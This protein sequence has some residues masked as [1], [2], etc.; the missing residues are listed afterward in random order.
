MQVS[1][2]HGGKWILRHNGHCFL[3]PANLGRKIK[4]GQ[5]PVELN[6]ALESVQGRPKKTVK[7]KQQLLSKDT[8]RLLAEKTVSLVSNYSLILQ[9]ALSTMILVLP[10]TSTARAI[11]PMPFLLFLFSAFWHELGHATALV[12]HGRRPGAIGV[13][14]L[15]IFPV[16][17]C[18][19]TATALLDRNQ[20]IR[21]DIS[22][23]IF[24]LSFAS[25]LHLLAIISGIS[26]F[27][28][29]SKL[30]LMA[31]GW[32]LIPF[33]RTDSYW[34]LCDL[35]KLDSL[36]KLP[37]NATVSIRWFVYSYRFGKTAFLA[38]VLTSIIW[39]IIQF[40]R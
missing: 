12:Y 28:T 38:I 4:S 24:Q 30:C 20:K 40:L 9:L 25:I 16:L 1:E 6:R 35:L 39:Q 23:V 21:V 13:G 33:L 3:I 14:V 15:M 26:E 27:E 34:L 22:G 8:V 5:C 31:V 19:V 7:L 10:F 2:Q 11:T 36:W 17:W 37:E 18:D 29:A 32:N